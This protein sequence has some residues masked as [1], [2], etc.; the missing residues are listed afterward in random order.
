MTIYLAKLLVEPKLGVF[1][2]VTTTLGRPEVYEV[3]SIKLNNR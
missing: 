2:S 3:Y 1:Y